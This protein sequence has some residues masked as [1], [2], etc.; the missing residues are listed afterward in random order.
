MLEEKD[1]LLIQ[2]QHIPASQ[3]LMEVR[4]RFSNLLDGLVKYAITDEK[5]ASLSFMDDLL[6]LDKSIRDYKNYY[7]YSLSDKERSLATELIDLSREIKLVI[8]SIVD[9]KDQTKTNIDSLLVKEKG[10]METLDRIIAL[11]KSG[12]S[13]KLGVGAALTEDIPAIHNISKIE[14]DESE[15]RIKIAAGGMTCALALFVFLGF[16]IG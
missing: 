10:F 13:S 5:D 9:L 11:K 2:A 7:G 8:N 16:Y 1:L 6:V 14:V 15:K 3:L 4:S 12:I